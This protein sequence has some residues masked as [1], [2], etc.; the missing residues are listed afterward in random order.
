MC[1]LSGELRHSNKI[2]MQLL[3]PEQRTGKTHIPYS[4]SLIRLR[5]Q[6]QCFCLLSKTSVFCLGG[7]L[8]H[9]SSKIYEISLGGCLI[10]QYCCHCC[11]GPL[12]RVCASEGAPSGAYSFN[13]WAGDKPYHQ[14]S[15][16]GQ[17]LI[18]S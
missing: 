15:S 3:F 4:V 6:M 18:S 13:E 7:G 5:T 1:E 17:T 9:T 2:I 8:S 10:T 14:L 12:Q 11:S 16:L